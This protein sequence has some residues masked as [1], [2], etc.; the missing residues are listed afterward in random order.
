MEKT[1][2][3][4]QHWGTWHYAKNRQHPLL[5]GHLCVPPKLC[6]GIAHATL[7]SAPKPWRTPGALNLSSIIFSACWSM[8]LLTSDCNR[9][10]EKPPFTR[11]KKKSYKEPPKCTAQSSCAFLGPGRTQK[12]HISGLRCHGM[13]CASGRFPCIP[14][15]ALNIVF[16]RWQSSPDPGRVS[17]CQLRQP[18][19]KSN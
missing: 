12:L 6:K 2:A 9:V 11:K 5:L 4:W 17:H 15:G 1:T 18:P 7:L 14:H 10:G 19:S 3:G 16:L 8:S 13:V